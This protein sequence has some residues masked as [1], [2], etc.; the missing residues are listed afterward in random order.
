MSGWDHEFDVVVVGSG[1]GGMT[2]ALC[3]QAKGLKTLLIEKD[4]VYGGTSAV[5]GGGIWIPNNDQSKAGGFDDSEADAREYVHSLTQGDTDPERVDA[6]LDAGPDMV[7]Y[8]SKEFGVEFD[9][10]TKYPDYFQGTPGVKP[11]FRSMEPSEFDARK[12]G[13]EFDNQRH[14]Y[15]GTLVMGRMAMSQAEANTLLTKANGWITLFIRLAVRYWFDL[16][17]RFKTKRDRHLHLGQALVGSLRHAM[18]K[19]DVALWHET[20]LT[21]VISENGRVTGVVANQKGENIRIAAAKGVVI[22]SGGF[23]SNQVLR[24]KYLPQPTK[25]EWS[26]GPGCNQGEGITAAE[27]VGAHLRDMDRVWGAPTVYAGGGNPATALFIERALPRSI[28]VDGSGQRYMNEAGAYTDVVYQMLAHQEKTGKAIPSWFIGDGV[29]RKEYPLGPV[30]PSVIMPDSKMP[31]EWENNVYYKADSIEQL[32]TN[33]GLDPATL[34]ATIEQ[35]NADAEQGKDSQFGRGENVFD[36][37]YGDARLKQK[38]QN[39]CMGPIEKPPFYAVKVFPGELG[40]AG[41]LDADKAGRV[42]RDDGSL[43]DGLYAIGNCSS[44]VMGRSYPGAGSTLGPAMVFGYLAAR[45]IAAA[46][47]DQQA[48]LSAAA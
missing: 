8:L 42:R 27:A 17:W 48:E 14:S 3:A 10:V 46:Q 26:A 21:E 2:A 9:L 1:A 16:P 36:R 43:I 47:S 31:K 13:D 45:D 18:Q 44:A 37:Y 6:Y 40:T 33:M 23:E 20:G 39:P 11:G 29:Y 19:L 25:K 5:S 41:G 30:M 22:A 38:Q 24:E 4:A 15:D 7:R 32:A 12:L 35:Y 28:M 34:K